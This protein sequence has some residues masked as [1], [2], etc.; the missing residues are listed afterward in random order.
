LVI[1][2]VRTCGLDKRCTCVKRSTAN[3][4]TKQGSGFKSRITYSV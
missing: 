2:M 1:C 3:R 4:P